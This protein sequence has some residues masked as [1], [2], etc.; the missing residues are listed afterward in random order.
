MVLCMH[1][2]KAYLVEP[3]AKDRAG[4]F[5]YRSNFVNG[6]EKGEPKLKGLVYVICKVL[7]N[8]VLSATECEIAAV[9]KS[10][11]DDTVLRR[12]LQETM[13]QYPSKPVQLDNIIEKKNHKRHLKT[14]KD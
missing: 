5:F 12:S 8:S 1:S 9:F 3:E 4:G 7:K 10:G 11:Q 14:K 13:H 6:I 2:D